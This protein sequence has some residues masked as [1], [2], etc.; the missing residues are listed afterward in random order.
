MLKPTDELIRNI[1]RGENFLSLTRCLKMPSMYKLVYK[2]DYI[3]R[4]DVAPVCR[5]DGQLHR[6][7][8]LSDEKAN[9]YTIC[10]C[11]ACDMFISHFVKY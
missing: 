4:A 7:Q 9:L 10:S 1:S 5:V 8:I 2:K 6:F 11:I 3:L